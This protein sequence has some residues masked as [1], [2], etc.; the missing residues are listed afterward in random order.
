MTVTPRATSVTV[1]SITVTRDRCPDA[2]GGTP[3]TR[4]RDSSHSRDPGHR[5]SSVGSDQRLASSPHL[6]VTTI[7]HNARTSRTLSTTHTLT[8]AQSQPLRSASYT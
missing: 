4:P 6:P 1:T 2:E 3:N 8:P 5:L 7:L